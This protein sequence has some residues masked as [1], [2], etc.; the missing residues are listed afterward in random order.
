MGNCASQLPFRPIKEGNNRSEHLAPMVLI[1]LALSMN[2]TQSTIPFDAHSNYIQVLDSIDHRECT[3]LLSQCIELRIMFPD[4]S[5][6]DR[7]AE[8]VSNFA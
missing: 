4:Q 3:D 8:S 7:A 2:K 5:P 1:V 6:I